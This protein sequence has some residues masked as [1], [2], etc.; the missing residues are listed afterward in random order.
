[1]TKN[2]DT[3]KKN[4]GVFMSLVGAFIVPHP[5]MIVKEIGRGGEKQKN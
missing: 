2:Y 1:M 3:I 4:R 5:P